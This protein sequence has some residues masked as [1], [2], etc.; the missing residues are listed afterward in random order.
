MV[1]RRRFARF[2]FANEMRKA[3]SDSEQHHRK[4]MKVKLLEPKVSEEKLHGLG[5][6]VTAFFIV[7][8]LV[9]GGVVAMPT[10]FIHTGVN[11]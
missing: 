10:A 9:G 11:N 8:D 2:C 6:A 4:E 3:I 1:A 5:W 7:A